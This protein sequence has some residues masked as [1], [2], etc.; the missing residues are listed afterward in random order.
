MKHPTLFEPVTFRHGAVAPNRLALAPL[1]NGQSDDDGT[2]GDDERRWLAR[3]AAGGFGVVATCASHVAPDGKGF[4]G[5]LGIWSD[6]HLHGLT[7]LA[8][9]I[10]SH[11]ALGLVQLYH[12][13]VRSPSS[14]TGQQPWSASVFHEDRPEFETPRA[15]TDDD[16]HGVIG[17]F[18]DAAVRA[19]R[20]G[21]AGVELHG[22]HGYLLSQFLSATM[23]TRGDAW[24]GDIA[25][26]ARLLREVTR[27]VRAVTRPGFVVGV[28]ISPEDFGYTRGV[29]LDETLTVAKWLADDGIDF[30]HLSLWN[31]ERMTAKRPA[32]HPI[33]AFRAALPGDVRIMA[34]GKVWEAAQAE[35]AIARGAD[36]VAVG[37]AGIVNPDWPTLVRDGAPVRHPPLTVA[38]YAARDVSPRFVA[39][40]RRFDGMVAD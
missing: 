22:A 18:R 35:A 14:L 36:L 3:R 33:T 9:E 39:Y 30:L 15:A 38:E 5:Q 4:A 12:G 19:D 2:L 31:V 6:A 40:L 13:G 32:E 23:N 26:R 37:R 24:G 16:I 7:A 27:S 29:D 21:F 20:A 1:T 8:A 25:G 28:R 11:G 10:A 17:Q 34:A